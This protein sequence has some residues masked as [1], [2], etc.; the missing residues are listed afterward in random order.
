MDPSHCLAINLLGRKTED[1]QL[2]VSITTEYSSKQGTVTQLRL[3]TAV[4]PEDCRNHVIL[5]EVTVPQLP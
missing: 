2:G 5:S 4:C 3:H 1:T